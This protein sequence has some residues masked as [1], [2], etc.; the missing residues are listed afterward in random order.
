[1]TVPLATLGVVVGMAA[2]AR[3]ARQAPWRVAVGGGTPEG[4]M[5]AARD[6][7]A[8]GAKGL[9]SFGLAGALAP[10]LKP[11][12]VLIPSAVVTL[13]DSFACDSAIASL[14]GLPDS[15]TIL[16]GETIVATAADKRR[17]WQHTGALAVDLESGA[18]ARVAR[19]AGLPF[20]VLRVICDPAGRDL[21]P[22]ALAA[23]DAAGAIG[24]TRVLASILRD[25]RQIPVLIALGREAAAAR[26]AL[27][28]RV[29]S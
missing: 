14:L 18:V 1:M 21:P 3:I 9:V 19:E 20:A 27:R 8:A 10:S 22:A 24:I 29:P 13:G 25:P 2:E 17:L 28:D 11:G 6:L 4:A 23:L 26:R 7:V 15:G 5:R 12:A 16:G